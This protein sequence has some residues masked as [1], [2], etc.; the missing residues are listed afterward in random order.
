LD[1]VTVIFLVLAIFTVISVVVA[2][3]VEER[4]VAVL[5]TAIAGLFT[6]LMFVILAAPDVAMTEAAIGSGLTTF[7]F[8][9]AL[10][11]IRGE[12]ND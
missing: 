12:K 7:I 5:A 8:F 3:I 11:N 4:S 1:I 6:A 2:S 10:K 9:F